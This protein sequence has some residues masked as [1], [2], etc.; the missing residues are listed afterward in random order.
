M[1]LTA[2]RRAHILDRLRADGSVRAAELVDDLGVSHDTIRRDLQELAD[3]GALRRVHGGALPPASAAVP[4]AVREGQDV[5]AKQAIAE[6]AIRCL[7]TGQVV[8]LD[9]GTTPLEVARRLPPELALTIVTNSPPVSVALAAHPRSEVVLAGGR[10]ARDAVACVGGAT[11]EAIAAVRADACVLG[12]CS[13]HPEIGITTDDL[14]ESRRGLGEARHGGRL[15]RRAGQRAHA[16][17]HRAGRQPVAARAVP[18]ARGR[19]RACVARASRSS[20]CSRPTGSA[21]PRGRRASPPCR[22]GST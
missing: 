22:T 14:E 4:Y 11:V 5:A 18:R 10:V 21:S 1:L 6:A 17:R 3:A 7:S 9:G 13:V 15:R 16:P 8:F 2:E 19:G 20:P 12:V